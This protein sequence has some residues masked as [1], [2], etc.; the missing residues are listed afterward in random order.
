MQSAVRKEVKYGKLK[1][2][3]L[4]GGSDSE[5]EDELTTGIL[6][7]LKRG[8]IENAGPD[9]A[10]P[11]IMRSSS[12]STVRG[13]PPPLPLAKGKTKDQDCL[14]MN[15]PTPV[16]QTPVNHI[17]RSS[18]K[19]SNF[20]LPTS[21][22]FRNDR[23]V[24]SDAGP[25]TRVQP[26]CLAVGDSPLA[27]GNTQLSGNVEAYSPCLSS[28]STVVD[29]PVEGEERQS[30]F[31]WNN[32]PADPSTPSAPPIAV[33]SMRESS[34]SRPS[35]PPVVM[36]STVQESLRSSGSEIKHGNEAPKKRISKFK[37]ERM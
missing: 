31:P 3:Q 14:D 30:A 25:S 34:S 15:L 26:T 5:P 17:I 21:A 27:S 12:A 19:V 9:F 37:A 11:A 6:D 24:A 2:D 29:S 4:V 28:A 18:P 33:S 1:D 36:V 22:K 35:L 7:L 13:R 20:N 8:Q 16:P 23:H 32:A 10:P